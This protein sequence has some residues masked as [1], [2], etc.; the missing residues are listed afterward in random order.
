MNSAHISLLRFA[1]RLSLVATLLAI[2]LNLPAR[3]QEPEAI[4]DKK[5]ADGFEPATI[6]EDST[7]Q[8][9]RMSVLFVAR[10]KTLKPANW[11]SIIPGVSIN[12]TNLTENDGSYVTE[13]WIVSIK[14]KKRLGVVRSSDENFRAYHAGQ[15]HNY[16]ST[17]WGPDQEG[18]HYGVL[19]YTGRWGC[20]EIFFVNCDGESAKVTS[21][22]AL[23]D[24]FSGKSIVAQKKKPEDYEIGYEMLGFVNPADSVSVS[25]PIKLRVA[26]TAQ[27]P[28]SE[29]DVVEGTITVE[30]SRN[31]K[32]ISTATVLSVKDGPHQ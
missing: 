7:S 8:D 29:D 9:G 31:E 13:N 5:L 10:K 4:F 27:I 6:L 2:V 30:L 18:W 15:N 14:D 32:G 26:Y 16:F 19:N 24:R 12:G 23:L 25:D 17:L 28:K 22:R 11:P 1:N 21:M 3:S 20:N